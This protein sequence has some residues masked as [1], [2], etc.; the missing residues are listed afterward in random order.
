MEYVAGRAL[1]A[2]IPASGMAAAETVRLAIPIAAAL[3]AAHEAGI[4]HRDLKPG[5][6]MVTD[7][8]LVKVVDFGPA[9]RAAASA[10]AAAGDATM[11]LAE[12]A[13]GVVVG[14]FAYMAPE[15]IQSR[16]VDARSDIWAFGCLLYRMLTGRDAFAGD[17]AMGTMAAALTREPVS[18]RELKPELPAALDRLVMGCLRKDAADRWHTSPW[19]AAARRLPC[20]S[21][22]QPTTPTPRGRQYALL[23]AALLAGTAF[24]AGLLWW[25]GRR[26]VVPPQTAV[27]RMATLDAGLSGWPSL[28]AMDP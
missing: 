3:A 9:K 2:L 20:R 8:G 7:R 6:V 14:T 5:N 26:T 11:T 4:V 13:P 22:S 28:C 18:L 15:Q 16:E 17:S 27:L 10:H 24:G 25:N 21:R 23:A 1:S 12:T 19:A